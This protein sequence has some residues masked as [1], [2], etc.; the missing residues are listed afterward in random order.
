MYGVTVDAVWLV[1]GFIDH[2]QVATTSN[3]SKN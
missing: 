3:Y 1:I 2:S